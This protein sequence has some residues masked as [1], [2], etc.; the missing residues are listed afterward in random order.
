MYVV[1]SYVVLFYFLLRFIRKYLISIL[2]HNQVFRVNI[3][4]SYNKH[5]FIDIRKLS[6]H[7]YRHI[8][9]RPFFNYIIFNFNFSSG[10]CFYS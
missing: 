9:Q 7:D 10:F 8:L 4:Q 6:I 5:I 2:S 1:V 3:C